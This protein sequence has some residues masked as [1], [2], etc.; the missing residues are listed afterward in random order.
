MEA[1]CAELEEVLRIDPQFGPA[2]GSL[3]REHALHGPADRARELAERTYAS[4]PRHPNAAG[5]LAG[6]LHVAGERARARE[7]LESLARE[8]E[9][10]FAPGPGRVSRRP[11]GDGRRDR[12]H[13][14][15]GGGAFR[16]LEPIA[17]LRA[18][19]S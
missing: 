5:F 13:R 1:G 10:S 16:V 9:W 6:M 12:S 4:L 2:L 11:R 18:D 15:S 19:R 7:V 17:N 8:S 3:G 14:A